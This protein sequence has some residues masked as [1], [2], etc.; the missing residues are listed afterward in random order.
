MAKQPSANPTY[1]LTY[2]SIKGLGETLRILFAYGG[3]K[4]EDV[5]IEEK[6]WPALKPTM[7]MGVVPVMDIDDIRVHQSLAMN[8]YIAKKV[9]LAG[10]NDWENLLIDIAV[11]TVND[12]NSKLAGAYYEPN[13]AVKQKKL[14]ELKEDVIPFYLGKLDVI[15]KEN[16]GYLALG[17][18]T[19]ADVFFFVIEDY[20]RFVMGSD[21]VENYPNLKNVITNTAS[22]PS[23]KVWLDKRPVTDY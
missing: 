1:K 23:I 8:R 14:A 5:R 4:Y 19:L 3:I 11:D 12:F 22:V 15:A 9:G 21:I 10:S 17:R 7:P 6:D 2:F 18:F 20:L 13:E 16:N